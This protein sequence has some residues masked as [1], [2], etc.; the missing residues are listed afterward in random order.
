MCRCWPFQY[1]LF[2]ISLCRTTPHKLLHSLVLSL[3]ANF[4]VVALD[5]LHVASL[6][7]ASSRVGTIGQL[8]VSLSPTWYSRHIIRRLH[9]SI[10]V[11]LDESIRQT[12]IS[13]S[14]PKPLHISRDAIISSRMVFYLLKLHQGPIL[15]LDDL[16]KVA[17]LHQLIVLEFLGV[18][19]HVL[20]Y[21]SVFFQ[22]SHAIVMVKLLC[23]A[24]TASPCE[25]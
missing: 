13:R 17:L 18:L 15:G 6:R 2:Q 3:H 24:T 20:L 23:D 1:V 12:D 7:G 10:H 11:A 22:Q 4:H 19:Y 8:I 14:L 25:S 16:I 9:L 21:Q 5:V